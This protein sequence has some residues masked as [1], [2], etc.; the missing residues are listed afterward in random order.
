MS[1]N[2]RRRHSQFGPSVPLPNIVTTF[3]LRFHLPNPKNPLFFDRL[4]HSVKHKP[5]LPLTTQISDERC[6]ENFKG[7]ALL[8]LN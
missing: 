1:I 4:T 7:S 5:S 3:I 8:T 6:R 2:S